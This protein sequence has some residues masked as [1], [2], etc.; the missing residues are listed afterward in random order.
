MGRRLQRRD[1]KEKEEEDEK[2]DIPKQ[3]VSSRPITGPERG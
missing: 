2:K 1:A 3:Q